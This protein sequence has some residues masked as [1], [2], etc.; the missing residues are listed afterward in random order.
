MLLNDKDFELVKQELSKLNLFNKQLP[1]IINTFLDVLDTK[2][3]DVP[4]DIKI[5]M[6][7]F[8]LSV[9]ATQ[10]KIKVQY[11]NIVPLNCLFFVFAPSATGKDLTYTQL[12]SLFKESLD[13]INEEIAIRYEK[14][15]AQGELKDTPLPNLEIGFS[16]S[17]G[18]L[19]NI[20]TLNLFGLGES[21]IYSGEFTSEFIS[22]PN[23]ST[24]FR[25]L[26]ELVGTGIKAVKQIKDS[27]R[28]T[29]RIDGSGLSAL[30]ATDMSRLVSD[31]NLLTKLKAFFQEGL[32]RRSNIVLI[33]DIKKEEISNFFEYMEQE[34]DNTT[35]HE[36]LKNKLIDKLKERAKKLIDNNLM[37]HTYTLNKKCQK[38]MFMYSHYLTKLVDNMKKE[39][40]NKETIRL[41]ALHKRDNEFRAV[42]LASAIAL[43]KNDLEL[44]TSHLISAIQI[45][46][47]LND[48]MVAL[49]TEL[50]KTIPDLFVEFCNLNTTHQKVDYKASDLLKAGFI[51]SKTNVK[52]PLE[53]LCIFANQID[54][55]SFYET[56]GK[57]VT[58]TK[59]CI[60]PNFNL[61]YKELDGIPKENRHTLTATEFFA[62]EFKSFDDIK[63]VLNTDCAYSNFTFR[64]GK[65]N[66]QSIDTLSS[67]FIFDIDC[68]HISYRQFHNLIKHI[69]HHIAKTSNEANDYKF[70]VIV[71]LDRQY[72]LDMKYYTKI[73]QY[74]VKNYLLNIP[75]DKLAIAQAYYGYKGREVLSVTNQ[76]KI[77][78][79]HI[80]NEI[81]QEQP[82][83]E[84]TLK[85]R[86]Q[87]LADTQL[88]T[89]SY[90]INIKEGG[91][92]NM[93]IRL[94]N[95]LKDL[96]APYD[97]AKEIVNIINDT[98]EP[99]LTDDELN[100]YIYP[101]LNKVIGE[102]ND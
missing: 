16:T 96:E 23:C 51:N 3:I 71:E 97:R 26:N 59:L 99:R 93:L 100:K 52:T 102:N 79:K 68:S 83:K 2:G 82:K 6:I 49:E 74:I 47:Y 1:P 7:T 10:F 21:F 34:L 17:E 46:E 37:G 44:N 13:V 22:N 42:R 92:S 63:T 86:K 28:Q 29:A 94:I 72:N 88:S 43:L 67:I 84:L 66:N 64:D 65:R 11:R 89:F 18:M 8:W 36:T 9:F 50:N 12:K 69:N 53:N 33:K 78:L 40:L 32:A 20:A 77:N 41:Y 73:R 98:Y 85:E 60:T 95:H 19:H 81:T 38:L 30:L 55:N 24:M 70:R 87:I 27:T 45:I 25:D 5:A 76:Q 39:A 62:R 14:L 101:H 56:D 35:K 48:G 91:R 54:E 90:A 61:S 57:T 80:L 58:H 15:K 31:N 75:V 4:R